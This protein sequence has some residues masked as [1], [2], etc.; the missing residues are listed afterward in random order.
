R[1]AHPPDRQPNSHPRR[2]RGPGT[3][4]TTARCPDPEL[5]TSAG[6]CRCPYDRVRLPP[7]KQP[8]NCTRPLPHVAGA[9]LYLIPTTT[10]RPVDD[11]AQSTAVI[12]QLDDLGSAI[13]IDIAGEPGNGTRPFPHVGRAKLYLIPTTTIRP[14]DD[15]AQSS[16][17]IPQLVDLGSSI[18][19]DIAG[20]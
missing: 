5:M 4:C 12:P 13:A 11:H 9:K 17:V 1:V 15:H 20:Q 19:I 10:I 7:D 18:D 8:G 14:V 6:S 3:C 16:A 2:S